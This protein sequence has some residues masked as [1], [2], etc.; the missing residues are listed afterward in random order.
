MSRGTLVDRVARDGHV[1]PPPGDNNLTICTSLRCD[2]PREECSGCG[3]RDC[4]HAV[5]PCWRCETRWEREQPRPPRR[6][7]DRMRIA[8]WLV[9]EPLGSKGEL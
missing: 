2:H 6:G 7:D 4:V 3:Y 8:S 1:R 9:L 5:S